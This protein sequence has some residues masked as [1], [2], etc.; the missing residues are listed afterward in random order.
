[1]S[2]LEEYRKSPEFITLQNKLCQAHKL[3]DNLWAEMHSK[4]PL[5]GKC[6]YHITERTHTLEVINY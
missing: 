3:I 2:Q 4:F 5:K 1:M 6:V